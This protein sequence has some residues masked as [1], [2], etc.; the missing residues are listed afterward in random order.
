MIPRLLLPIA[1]VL[2]LAGCEDTRSEP[3]LTTPEGP[4]PVEQNQS[5]I[6]RLVAQL[7]EG[8]DTADA[9]ASKRYDDAIAALIGRG[10][11]IE[12]N[13]IDH[14]RR[15]NDWSIRI[16]LIEVLQAVG[17]KACI[18]HLIVML[19]DAEPLVAH[20][21][22]ATLEELCQHQEIPRKATTGPLPPV[23]KPTELALDAEQKVWATWHAQYKDALKNAWLSWWD[24]H[25]DQAVIN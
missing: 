5:E 10:S 24:A 7:A 3:V 11:A 22:N 2:I 23:P 8:K 14:L 4:S 25:R 19:D 20:R 1:A 12:P 21:A 9:K 6:D 18:E 15:S 16:G 17:S 13:L